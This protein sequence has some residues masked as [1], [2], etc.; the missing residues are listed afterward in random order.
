LPPSNEETAIQGLKLWVELLD[1]YPETI[2]DLRD[3]R[4]TEKSKTP[5]ALR[6]QEEIKG[7]KEGET[8]IKHADFLMPIRGLDRFYKMLKE[9][10][11]DPAYY[12]NNVTLK[13]AEKVLM[14]WKLSD[15]EYRVI[16]GDLHAE[17]VTP[18]K[19]AELEAALPK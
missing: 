19:L 9:D 2:G 14:R 13:D 17:T 1:K 6:F 18:A 5:A 4:L 10:K 16:Y 12:G 15:T 11:K 8:I 7:L 3:L